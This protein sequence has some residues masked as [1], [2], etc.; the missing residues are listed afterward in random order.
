MAF[1]LTLTGVDGIYQGLRNGINAFS[2]ITPPMERL[3][4]LQAVALRA[5]NSLMS[6]IPGHEMSPF[7]AFRFVLGLLDEPLLPMN[8]LADKLQKPKPAADIHPNVQPEA[9]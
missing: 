5:K 8:C 1:L 4:T 6:E 2:K 9:G 3:P 7:T